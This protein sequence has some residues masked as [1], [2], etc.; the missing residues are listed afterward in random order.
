MRIP[1]ISGNWKIHKTAAEARA[2]AEE[3]KA[4]YKDTDVKTAICAPFV[5][6]ALLKEAFAGT[7]IK[8]GAQNAHF[9]DQGAFTGEI[10][11]R[12]LE[13]IGVDYCIIGH[14][15]RRQYFAETDETVNKKLKKLFEG[16]IV[17]ILCVG[18]VLEER[19]AGREK[20]VVG[21]QIRADLAGLS[22]DDVRKLVVAYEP[23]WAIG[24][25]RTATPEQANEMCGYIREVISEL[26]D[27]D[28]AC[29]VTIQYGGSMKPANATELM[30]M[31]E[32]DG[33]LIGGSSL[34]ADEFMQIIDF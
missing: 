3:F 11:V 29:D 10:S 26:Y 20:E 12:M 5:H 33:G 34:K 7:D 24:T 17:P 6:L 32:I 13:D 4:L 28:V 8:V 22:A 27:D 18:E 15:E 23:V 9:E 14:S 30:A 21:G 2:F 31:E 16:P 1:F 25:G 19:D